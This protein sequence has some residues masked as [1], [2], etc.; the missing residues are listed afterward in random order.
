MPFILNGHLFLYRCD[1]FLGQSLWNEYLL[2]VVFRNSAS[3]I[4]SHRINC[5]IFCKRLATLSCSNV[6]IST[7]S[8]KYYFEVN[9]YAFWNVFIK[10]WKGICLNFTSQ[11][12]LG[13]IFCKHVASLSY[14]MLGH[15][16][17]VS[18]VFM[19]KSICMNFEMYL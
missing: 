4:S 8:L 15:L 6:G 17:K 5:C 14:Q 1:K 9:L 12:K 3:G 16:L 11:D 10:T 13:C 18:N 7:K 2:M 19:F